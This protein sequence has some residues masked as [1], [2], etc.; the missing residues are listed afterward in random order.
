MSGTSRIDLDQLTALA[1]LELS[2]EERERFLQDMEAIVA[3]AGELPEVEK[4]VL[5]GM[6]AIDVSR[7]REDVCDNCFS[8]EDLLACAY[9]KQD[10]YIAVPHVWKEKS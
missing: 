3:F 1:C 9:A 7:L 10:G 6:N 5:D 4:S 8:R 2:L